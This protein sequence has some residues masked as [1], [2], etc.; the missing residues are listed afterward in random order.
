MAS[1]V[2]SLRVHYSN[3]PLLESDVDGSG[4]PMPLFRRWFDEAVRAVLR[5]P[6]AMTLATATADGK[7]S[8][9]VVL[10][11]GYDVDDGSF[12]WY[13][14]YDSRKAHELAA[15]PQAALVFWW[16]ELERSVRVEGAVERLDSE[17]SDAYFASRPRGSRIGAWASRQS[18]PI[19]SR[20][21]LE[22]TAAEWFQRYDQVE[23]VPRPPY[24]G[25]F[26]L[27]ARRIEFWKGRA[28]RLHDRLSFEREQVQGVASQQWRLTRLQP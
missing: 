3:T 15:N 22:R 26:R 7:P 6:N 19:A 8:A 14:N 16:A 9:R 4:S 10:L 18:Q 20:A 5:E 21:V 17:A 12:V 1:D 25:G 11:K 23:Q 28:N 24:W 27:R 13:S 2:A